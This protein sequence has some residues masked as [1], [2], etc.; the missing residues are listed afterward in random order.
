[1][2]S[3]GSVIEKLHSL[4]LEYS[5]A[6]MDTQTRMEY[7]KTSLSVTLKDLEMSYLNE[8]RSEVEGA[9]DEMRVKRQKVRDTIARPPVDLRAPL[10]RKKRGDKEKLPKLSSLS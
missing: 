2:F 8:L 9:V 4:S 1:M 6:K 3:D 7:V 5:A 10:E